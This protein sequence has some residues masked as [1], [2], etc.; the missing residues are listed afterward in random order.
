[1]TVTL[2]HHSNTPQLQEGA[3]ARQALHHEGSSNAYLTITITITIIIITIIIITIIIII[4]IIIITIII[5]LII[6]IITITI[7][8]TITTKGG[9]G[10]HAP[11]LLRLLA[12]V[13]DGGSLFFVPSLVFSMLSNEF[14]QQKVSASKK[15]GGAKGTVATF[16]RPFKCTM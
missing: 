3:Q 11:R 6:I 12:R 1:M 10:V 14:L 7:T 13:Q 8:I 4:I 15:A 9:V 2:E 5:I 16:H